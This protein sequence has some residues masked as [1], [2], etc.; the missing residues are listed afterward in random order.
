M[1]HAQNA[2]IRLNENRRRFAAFC[3][4]PQ[5]VSRHHARSTRSSASGFVQA[6]PIR[7]PARAQD[8][9]LRPRVPGYRAGDLEARYAT[10]ADRGR[11]LH[12]LRL[13]DRGA[14]GADASARVALADRVEQA[15]A[16]D[17]RVRARARL[18]A[19]ARSRRA[20]RARPRHE[21]LGR[22]IER[23]D[24]PARADA[25]QGHAAR[26]AARQRHPRLCAAATRRRAD[27]RGRSTRASR[28]ARRYR[29]RT[30]R[31]GPGREPVL[32]R[33]PPALR[34]AALARA[35]SGRAF[36]RAKTRLAHA[37]IDGHTWYWP[38]GRT[39]VERRRRSACACSRRSIRW[40]GIDDASR[41]CGTGRIDSRPTR[42]RRSA[43]L[44]TTR[45][46]CCGAIA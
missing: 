34:H 20:F 45:C 3:R 7:A 11:L 14:A 40:C 2:S 17:P 1:P 5:P 23:D 43:S 19:S 35:R 8:L 15:R 33:Q 24:A 10:L 38:D 9:T 44:A 32:H 28:R 27:R 37:T 12:Q 21:L 42:R 31:A 29:R 26:R 39:P 4:Q 25:L 41:C 22:L 13:R 6:D 36:E 16:G 30:L 46:R 18:G